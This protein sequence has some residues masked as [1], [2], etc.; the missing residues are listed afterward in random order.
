MTK[1][2]VQTK[3]STKTAVLVGVLGVAALAAAGGFMM[4][5]AE[6]RCLKG[7]YVSYVDASTPGYGTPGYNSTPGYESTPG[8]TSPYVIQKGYFVQGPKYNAATRVPS[9]CTRLLK[10][11][12]RGGVSQSAAPSRDRR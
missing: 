5:G 1:T 8:Y 4:S 11:S 9:Y 6:A 2:M 7:G 10:N 12:E 3:T